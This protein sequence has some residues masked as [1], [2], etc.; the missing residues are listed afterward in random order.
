MAE[1]SEL[2]EILDRQSELIE[3]L[4]AKAKTFEYIL[5]SLKERHGEYIQE[6]EDLVADITSGE[7]S[8]GDFFKLTRRLYD[9]NIKNAVV[10]DIICF[11]ETT[12]KE[13][14]GDNE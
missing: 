9:L 7:N 5:K 12:L 6:G 8:K 10:R 1:I 3:G 13:M 14:E 4:G 11:M 2:I